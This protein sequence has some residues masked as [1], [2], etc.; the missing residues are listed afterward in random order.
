MV[1]WL[2]YSQCAR[3]QA[4][5]S[6]KLSESLTGIEPVTLQSH[7]RL[8]GYRFDSRQ[9]LRKF[10]G[11]DS[12]KACALRT[13]IFYQINVF[14]FLCGPFLDHIQNTGRGV[15]IFGTEIVTALIMDKI[16]I[17]KGFR[18]YTQ[19]NLDQTKV[20][21]HSIA[22]LIYRSQSICNASN[23]YVST[24]AWIASVFDYN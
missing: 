21:K 2:L 5:L 19:T 18:H 4:V 6:E 7:R 3:S 23:Y 17:I 13:Y 22:K 16:T 8:E 11:E 20:L 1:A 12:L 15:G 24:V 14:L 9:W 10:F